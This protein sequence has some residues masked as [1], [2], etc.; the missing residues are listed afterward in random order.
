V[1]ISGDGTTTVI[2]ADND[3][4]PN[5]EDAG[6][7]YVFSRDGGTW[8]QQAK[9]T[10][11]DG[12]NGDLFGTS[13][14]VPSDGTTAL[15]L[16]G[17]S[18]YVFGR[19]GDTWSQQAK[20][21]ADDGGDNFVSVAVS[22][23]GTTAV[24]GAVGGDNPNGAN[25]GSA[26]VFSQ[27]SDSWNQQTKL[28]A[29]DGDEGDVFG[30]QVAVSSDATTAVIGAIDDED[31]NGEDAGSA[32]VFGSASSSPN[33][34][35]TASFTQTPTSPAVGD[36]VTFDAAG[37]SESDGTIQT[38]AWDLDGDGSYEQTGQTVAY[39]FS[40][41]GDHTVTLRVTDDDGA[42]ATTSQTVTVAGG[43]S[44]VHPNLQRFDTNGQA[45]I[46]ADEIV[47]AIVA[48]NSGSQI[49]GESVRASD[50]VDLIVEY[51]S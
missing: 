30:F 45:G 51:N 22:G 10:A 25:A 47:D 7:A 14:A 11:D 21:T 13:V 44:S 41:S 28:L 1:A 43:G 4:N 39:T 18:G 50:V 38:Y 8:V 42:T 5:G 35:P 27:D 16:G 23:D 37:S 17:G 31:P 40:T 12:N 9:L 26:Y 29:D 15:I 46:Q 32:Y 34:P 24:F 49:G 33:T 20:L 3:D 6:S 2:G 48:Y 19:N 36:S